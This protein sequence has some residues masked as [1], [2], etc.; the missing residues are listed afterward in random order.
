MHTG[1]GRSGKG[2]RNAKYEGKEKERKMV[3]KKRKMEKG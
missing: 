2:E 1:G 3:K